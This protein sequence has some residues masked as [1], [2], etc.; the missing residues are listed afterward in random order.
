ML[1]TINS[2]LIRDI[3]AL[4]PDTYDFHFEKTLS[5]LPLATLINEIHSQKLNGMKMSSMKINLKFPDLHCEL[6]DK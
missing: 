6:F 2:K 1:E 4:F 5:C 3:V